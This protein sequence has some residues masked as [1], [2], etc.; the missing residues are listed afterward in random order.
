MD[1]KEDIECVESRSP[2]AADDD[3]GFTPREQRHI[4]HKIDRRLILGLGLLFAASLIDRTNLGNA[5]IAG[6]A[7]NSQTKTPIDKPQDDKRS[8]P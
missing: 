5:A 8:R 7:L 4:I 6:W 3:L 2:P 1:Q